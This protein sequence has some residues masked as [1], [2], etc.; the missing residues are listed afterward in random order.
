MDGYS[1]VWLLVTAGGAAL[2][3]AAIAIGIMRNRARTPS[4]TRVS[5][6]ATRDLY[7]A[8]DRR[9]HGQ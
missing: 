8:E 5:E 9:V 4:E 2:L 6:Q 3:G 7:K 1:I